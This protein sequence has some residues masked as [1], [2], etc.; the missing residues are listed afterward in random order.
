MNIPPG[1]RSHLAP[2]PVSAS[3][4]LSAASTEKATSSAKM[5]RRTKDTLSALNYHNG[6]GIQLKNSSQIVV[7]GCESV[8]LV[9]VVDTNLSE[10]IA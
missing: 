9:A 1:R 8:T 6:E 10:D 2:S 7:F 3:G 4:R 5:E